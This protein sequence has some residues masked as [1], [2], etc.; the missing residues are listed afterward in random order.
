MKNVLINN[1]NATAR[2]ILLGT[3]NHQQAEHERP[4]DLAYGKYIR[5]FSSLQQKRKTHILL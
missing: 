5:R 4:E 3:T 2:A 1:R